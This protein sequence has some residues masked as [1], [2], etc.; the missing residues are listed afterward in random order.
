MKSIA[1]ALAAAAL[2][3][4]LPAHAEVSDEDLL[5][6]MV[7]SRTD[8]ID[9]LY[10]H[11]SQPTLDDYL[12]ELGIEL[13]VDRPV[14]EGAVSA[15]RQCY[16]RRGEL[17]SDYR[18]TLETSFTIPSIEEVSSDRRR[19]E[20][21]YLRWML[22]MTVKQQYLAVTDCAPLVQELGERLAFTD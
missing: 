6:K 8:V 1:G 21:Q 16:A 19:Y 22:Q 18:R 2:S 5:V 4:C 13:T 14:I 7:E 17:L 9:D 3:L 10:R 20:E 12:S 11:L 15:L